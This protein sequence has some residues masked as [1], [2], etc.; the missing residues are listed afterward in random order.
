MSQSRKNFFHRNEGFVCLHC[1]AENPPQD[2]SCRNHC[3]RCLYSR[4][5]DDEVPGDRAST[6]KALM[7]PA[8]LDSNGKKGLMIVH[9]CVRCRKRM[10]NKV[11]EDDDRDAVIGLGLSALKG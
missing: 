2:G 11:A 3:T 7:S 8:E 6:C 10:K 5:V 4:H 9:Q 1:G